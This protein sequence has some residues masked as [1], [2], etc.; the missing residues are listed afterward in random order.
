[1]KIYIDTEFNEFGGEL[2]SMALVADDGQEFYEVL[3][4]PVPGAWVSEHVMPFLEKPVVSKYVF[5]DALFKFLDQYQHI[6]I[7]ADWAD[8]LKYFCESLILGPGISMGHPPITMELCRDLSSDTSAVPH[9]ALH[10]ARAI[11]MADLEQT[12]KDM[13]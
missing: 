12:Y 3:A 4:C 11:Q 13:K 9:N 1:M 7:I 10:D 2:I 5:Q 8:D 6:H